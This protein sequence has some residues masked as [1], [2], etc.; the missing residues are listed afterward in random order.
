MKKNT[1]RSTSNINK[2]EKVI[3]ELKSK[4]SDTSWA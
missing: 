4:L 2:I 3:T 1:I